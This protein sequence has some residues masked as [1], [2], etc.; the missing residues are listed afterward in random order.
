MYNWLYPYCGCPNA[1][2]LWTRDQQKNMSETRNFLAEVNSTKCVLLFRCQIWRS[3]V[4]L[5]APA[6]I[7]ACTVHSRENVCVTSCRWHRIL[8]FFYGVGGGWLLCP[9][10]TG[11]MLSYCTAVDFAVISTGFNRTVIYFFF[12]WNDKNRVYY[13]AH[14]SRS[15][16]N[17]LQ[18]PTRHTYVATVNF[19][20][21]EF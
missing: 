3:A 17:K 14:A 8:T 2:W 1:C 12:H 20:S 16:T 21:I 10:R 4:G 6:V 9:W 13:A 18:A 11:H 15:L 19:F 7:T 5:H